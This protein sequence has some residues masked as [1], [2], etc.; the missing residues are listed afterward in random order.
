MIYKL[1]N[2]YRVYTTSVADGVT[3][4]ETRNAEG[5]IISTVT[6]RGEARS[7]T[8]ANLRVADAIRLAAVYGVKAIK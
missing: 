3:E 4:F 6:L 7:A 5:A 1:D 8:L 2:G